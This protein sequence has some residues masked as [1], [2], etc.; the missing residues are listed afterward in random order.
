MK[1]SERLYL[2]LFELSL[3]QDRLRP[4]DDEAS[5]SDGA[6]SERS[7]LRAQTKGRDQHGSNQKKEEVRT[8]SPWIPESSYEKRRVGWADWMAV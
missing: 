8:S 7:D 3:E 4:R 6:Y 5:E 2:F 1:G